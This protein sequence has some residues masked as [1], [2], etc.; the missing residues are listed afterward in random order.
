MADAHKNFA[1][2]AVAAAPSPATTGPSLDVRAGEGARF[3]ATP[4]NATVWPANAL[5]DPTNAEIVRVANITSDT[6]TIS[7]AQEGTTARSVQAG[8]AIAA[9][10]TAKALTDIEGDVAALSSTRF[11]S[12]V[13][14]SGDATG[15]T[16]VA[17]V[18]AAL[19][20]GDVCLVGSFL[21]N[22]SIV[23]PSNRTL[24]L[25]GATLALTSGANVPLIV[26]SDLTNGNSNISVRGLGSRLV[27]VLDGN[28]ANQ[29]RQTTT[30]QWKNNLALFV[31]V[32]GLLVREPHRQEP[33]RL[34]DLASVRVLA[35][36]PAEPR[37]G[38]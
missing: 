7:R 8:D 29:T 12:R 2:S 25:L 24:Y 32:A 13:S 33:E 19:V 5:P 20:T 14:P 38:R 9:T 28:G 36:P 11:I 1:I 22:A 35:G 34:G 6:L 27:N 30:N 3:P 10:V 16:D 31:K 23:I 18:N 21:F 17:N 26:N 4:F 37:V 15:A